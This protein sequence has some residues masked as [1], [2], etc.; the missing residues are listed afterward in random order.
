M[1]DISKFEIDDKQAQE[2]NT[3][4]RYI[5]DSGER[6][7]KFLDRGGVL[8]SSTGP[9]RPLVILSF[10]ESHVLTDTPKTGGWT[11]FVELRRTLREIVGFPIFSLFL[12]TAGRFHLFSPEIRSDPSTRV[13]RA[14]L[15]P[16]DPISEVSFDDLAFPAKEYTVP[17][18]RVVKLDWISHLGR[19]LYVC[20]KHSCE[21]LLTSSLL[22]V[23]L[24]L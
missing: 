1:T 23:R 16:L 19:P 15:V 11:L 8:D 2:T 14:D 21:K 24:A 5:K 12:S 10:D 13:S 22:Q 7:C 18:S 6:L 9:R 20:L 3:P 4:R 17:L